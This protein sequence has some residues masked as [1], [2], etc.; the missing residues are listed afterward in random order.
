MSRLR[1]LT[2]D[3]ERFVEALVTV[4]DKFKS[5]EI[6]A[7]EFDMNGWMSKS[8]NAKTHKCGTTH[9]IGG[10]VDLELGG[11]GNEDPRGTLDLS[12]EISSAARKLFIPTR[13]GTFAAK[14]KAAIV[15]MD[16]FLAGR[17]DPWKGVE[18]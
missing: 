5:A 7:K 14:K 15:A 6:K 3:D 8:C 10:F 16:N 1:I 13:E 9:C 4:R 11:Y 17:K 2:S 12:E 18:L